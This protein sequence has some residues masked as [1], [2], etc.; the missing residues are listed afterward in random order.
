M[1]HVRSEHQ[2]AASA[3]LAA[4]TV[5][6]LSQADAARVLPTAVDEPDSEPA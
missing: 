5:H 3:I 6:L 1:R 4:I 2:L